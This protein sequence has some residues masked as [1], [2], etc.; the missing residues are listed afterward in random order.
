MSKSYLSPKLEDILIAK[1]TAHAA[2]PNPAEAAAGR[3]ELLT[4]PILN[5]FMTEE[6]ALGTL[7]DPKDGNEI[8][9]SARAIFALMA[10][11]SQ[12]IST[13]AVD[14]ASDDPR[15]VVANLPWEMGQMLAS[16]L[17][18][19]ESIALAHKLLSAKLINEAAANKE[20]I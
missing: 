9:S 11:S 18:F 10:V 17:K 13:V 8:S 20:T 1:A 4:I 6:L 7:T 15:R 5:K 14:R 16:D 12:M 3:L 19:R 2:D